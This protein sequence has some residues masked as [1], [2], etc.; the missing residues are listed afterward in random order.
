MYVHVYMDDAKRRIRFAKPN[1][2]QGGC[3]N[4][5]PVQEKDWF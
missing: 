5:T 1:I 4:Q 2:V 3:K